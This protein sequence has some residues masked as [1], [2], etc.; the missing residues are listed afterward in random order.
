LREIEIY[1]Y[2]FTSVINFSSIVEHFG[3]YPY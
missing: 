1:T 2:L 3:Y